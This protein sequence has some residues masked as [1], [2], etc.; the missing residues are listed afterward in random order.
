MTD[1]ARGALEAFVRAA[2][3]RCRAAF[4]FQIGDRVESFSDRLLLA[5][6]RP[7]LGDRGAR[8]LPIRRAAEPHQRRA[9]AAAVFGGVGEAL[10]ERMAGQQRLHD[11]ALHADAPAVDQPDLG[12]ATR[13]GLGEIFLDD[14]GDVRG[15]E[16]VEIEC[17]LDRDAD[18][19]VGIVRGF[20]GEAT[21]GGR[22]RGA[23]TS[24]GSSRD[25]PPRACTVRTSRRARRTARRSPWPR[26]PP[27]R[28]RPPS[29]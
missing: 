2:P 5:S 12:K 4:D 3:E 28:S 27:A 16:R 18:R 23:A 9:A 10:D 25:P 24:A 13:V 15:P 21:S 1:E 26:S 20:D 11:R 8:R 7:R 29:A 22:R 19:I 6:R 14:R 17:V